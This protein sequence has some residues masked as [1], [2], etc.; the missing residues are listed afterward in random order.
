MKVFSVY[1]NDN[2]AML[3]IAAK[4]ERQ[5][6][7]TLMSNN[8]SPIVEQEIDLTGANLNIHEEKMLSTT[9]EKP[10]VLSYMIHEIT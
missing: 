6:Y 10:T 5:A 3:I 9:I 2:Q 7:D 8:E 4:D 1:I